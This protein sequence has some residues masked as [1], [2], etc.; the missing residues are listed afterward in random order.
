MLTHAVAYAM[1]HVAQLSTL[2]ALEFFFFVQKG[3]LATTRARY[4]VYFLALRVKQVNY[5]YKST[6]ADT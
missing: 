3:A 1:H 2:T 6:N 4:S 5:S